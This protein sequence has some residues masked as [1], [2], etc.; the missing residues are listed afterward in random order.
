MAF[1][2]PRDTQRFWFIHHVLKKGSYHFGS[3]KSH[4]NFLKPANRRRIVNEIKKS[5]PR[6]LSRWDLLI[7][8]IDLIISRIRYKATL[9]DYLIFEFWKK[10]DYSR[11]KVITEGQG[12]AFW[13]SF[14]QPEFDHLFRNKFETYQILKPFYGREI[15]RFNG[16][17]PDKEARD[18]LEMRQR[19]FLKPND[20]CAGI[21]T[22]I[23]ETNEYGIDVDGFL[24]ELKG[25]DWIFED[26]IE[27]EESLS[28]IHPSSINTIRVNSVVTRAGVKLMSAVFK[29]GNDQTITD[30]FHQGGI[31][32][33]L[34][35]ASGI[36]NGIPSDRWNR[37]FIH[38]PLS[39]VKLVGFQ[40][41]C[42]QQVVELAHQLA[43]AVPQ[44][45]FVGWD[46]ALNSKST[47]I[48]VEGNVHP[49]FQVQSVVLENMKAAYLSALKE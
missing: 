4:L 17:G 21:G 20:S 1:L 10:T 15:V 30:N 6:E 11:K 22:R 31:A 44:V 34:D 27:Q 48:V 49:G 47:P 33:P 3:V 28:Q 40:I 35:L 8:F 12:L 23:V 37:S 19:F 43:S 25:F 39:G 45:R 5:I 46:I 38:H 2:T 16:T 26:L 32:A 13:Q 18:F 36:I 29:M 9:E 24:R 42:W 14:N 7:T 41:P